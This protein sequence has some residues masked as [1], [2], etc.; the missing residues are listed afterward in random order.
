[1]Y[2]T[3]GEDSRVATFGLFIVTSCGKQI[4]SDE[5]TLGCAGPLKAPAG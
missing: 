4:T 5:D 2:T 1:M 3:D